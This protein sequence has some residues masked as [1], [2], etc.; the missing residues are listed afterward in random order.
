M[1]NTIGGERNQGTLPLLMASPAKRIPLFL[2]RA[3]P[4]ILNGFL[5]A[6]VAL[7]AGALLLGVPLP[8]GSWAPLANCDRGLLDLVHR[9]RPSR[10]GDHPTGPR[11]SGDVQ[12]DFR[13]IDDF[14]RSQ[15]AADIFARL[16]VF[17]GPL[18]AVDPWHRCG[19][20][21]GGRKSAYRRRADLVTE[22][23]LGVLYAG[24]GL[25]LLACLARE[26]RRKATLDIY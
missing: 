8:V 5:V 6:V 23:G 26:S 21:A 17:G 15:R 3:L 10:R 11:D 22:M 7:V 14:R 9:A 4:V 16:D 19:T 18:A 24:L 2:G 13:C 1:G 20:E 12:R 25:A